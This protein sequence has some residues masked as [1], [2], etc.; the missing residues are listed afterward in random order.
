MRYYELTIKD[1][2]IKIPKEER[3]FKVYVEPVSLCN[4]NCEMCFINQRPDKG[5]MV[6][7]T[8]EK[9]MRDLEEIP[10]VKAILFGGIGEPLL[11]PAILSMI[12]KAKKKG[13]IVSLQTNGA[14][15]NTKNVEDLV[16]ALDSITFSLDPFP[17]YSKSPPAGIGHRNP[18]DTLSK[19]RLVHDAK[20]KLSSNIV[21][22]VEG[23]IHAGNVEFLPALPSQLAKLGVSRVLI[24]NLVPIEKKFE[25][26][27]LYNLPAKS[28]IDNVFVKFKHEC[29]MH[30]IEYILPNF[31]LTAERH[32]GFIERKTTVIRWDGNVVPCYRFLHNH[33]EVILGRT[34]KIKAASF[35][36]ILDK[37]LKNIWESKPYRT[38]R[39]K[40][41]N[42][43]FP[44]CIH[45]PHSKICSF[46]ET[47]ERDC[48]GN[49]PSCGDCLWSHRLV[50][51][52]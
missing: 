49:V 25:R 41:K 50:M 22:S 8:F 46:T 45:C 23:V 44:S 14:L 13:Y 7:Q 52:P 2:K 17:I 10:S 4:F 5:F 27:A 20:S 36:N 38:F 40:V 28:D 39:F 18:Q 32:C 48:W 15:I 19:I 26:L 43:I 9:L 34:K 51:C 12:K 29:A 42:F 1:E 33:N 16:R 21:I 47:N 37:S 30:H 6:L 31:E 3:L 11:H 24:S 35:G